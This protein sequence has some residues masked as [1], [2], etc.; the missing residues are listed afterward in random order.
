MT[1]YAFHD[2]YSELVALQ[3]GPRDHRWFY[4]HDWITARRASRRLR[5]PLDRPCGS[6]RCYAP[7]TEFIDQHSK[8]GTVLTARVWTYLPPAQWHAWG[9]EYR[10]PEEHHDSYETPVPQ[11]D[12]TPPLWTGHGAA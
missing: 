12:V 3:D 8:G 4:Y 11:G 10:T 5:V 2:P 6:D 1:D 7:T 9:R